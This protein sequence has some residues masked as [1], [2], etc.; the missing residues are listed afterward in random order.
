MG[1]PSKK[2]AEGG[3]K[4]VKVITTNIPV[5]R[6]ARRLDRNIRKYAVVVSVTARG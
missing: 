1:K 6:M 2:P 3:G 5:N 4:P